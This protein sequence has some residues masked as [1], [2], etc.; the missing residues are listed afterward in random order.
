[1]FYTLTRK[2]KRARARLFYVLIAVCLVVS[3]TIGVTVGLLIGLNNNK[4]S[5]ELLYE[6]IRVDNAMD[7]LSVG[8]IHCGILLCDICCYSCYRI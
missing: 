4:S 3:I 7:T 8:A 6:N 2:N 1:M 5:T